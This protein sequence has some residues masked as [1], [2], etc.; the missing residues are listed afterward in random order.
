MG[1]GDGPSKA[2]LLG[3]QIDAIRDQ[4]IGDNKDA[5]EKVEDER[6]AADSVLHDRINDLDQKFNDERVSSAKSLGSAAA[7]GGASA[8]LFELLQY[9]TSLGG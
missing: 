6:R 9:F 7:G 4:K 5:I 3:M 2:T 8:G 1:E